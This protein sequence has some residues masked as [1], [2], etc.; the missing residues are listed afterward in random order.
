MTIYW[1]IIQIHFMTDDA[2][3]FIL[4]WYL[5]E[6]RL[7]K[8]KKCSLFTL[9]T[10]SNEKFIEYDARKYLLGMVMAIIRNCNLLMV[11]LIEWT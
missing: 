3:N 4:F 8:F 1:G 6:I 7:L 10:I 2:S 9:F 5:K 11:R